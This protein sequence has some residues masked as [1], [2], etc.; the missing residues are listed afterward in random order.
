MRITGPVKRYDVVLIGGGHNGLTCAAYLAR[1]GLRVLVCE[2]RHIVGGPCAEYEYFPGYRASITNSPGSLEPRVV[3]D[4]ELE[5]HGLTF[6]HPDPTLMFPFPDGRAFV[7][8]RDRAQVAEQIRRFS[9]RDVDGY[10]AL[11]EYLNR[12][13]ERLGASL[14]E[15]PPTLRELVSR[16]ETPEDEEAFAKVFLGSVSDLLDEFLESAHLKSMLAMLGVMSNWLSPLSPGSATWLM[17]R[18]MSLASS[19]VAAEHDPRRQVLRGSTGLPLGGMGSIVR[20]MRASLEAAGGTV[21]TECAIRQILVDGERAIGVV[22]EDGEEVGAGIVVSNLD[23]WTTYLDLIEAP[24]L[25]PE[26]RATVERLP[27]RGSAFK[28]ALALDA[29]PDFAAAPKGLERACAGCQFRIAPSIEYQDQAFEDAKHGRPSQGPVF[30][31]LFPTMADPTLAPPGRHILSANIFHAPNELSDGAWSTERDRFGEHCIDVLEEYLPGL[32]D[33]IVDRR[34]WSPADLEAEFG[35]PGA[36]ITHLD[37]TPR[38]M[39]GLRPVAGFSD[40]RSPIAGLYNCGS[41]TWPGGTVTGAPGYN[42][43][44]Q[45]L[46]DLAE[47]GGGKS[48]LRQP[49]AIEGTTHDAPTDRTRS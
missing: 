15:A 49:S 6:T 45:V 10:A 2:R 25:P 12:F 21:R 47:G 30:W 33:R 11:F 5:R 22:L 24:H 1:A 9:P 4:L 39:F 32:R 7:G 35:L 28:V 46:A 23:P 26:F 31:G 20:A 29:I 3:A 37:M 42:A 8:W 14:F 34:F 19:S 36:N 18:P 40:H 38:H 44:R 27:R 13:A 17:M 48:G 16:L 41:S 43:G